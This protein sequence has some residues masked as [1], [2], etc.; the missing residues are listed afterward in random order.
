MADIVIARGLDCWLFSD[1]VTGDLREKQVLVN[2][3]SPPKFPV[4]MDQPRDPQC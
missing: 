2:D 1:F 4:I 3:W